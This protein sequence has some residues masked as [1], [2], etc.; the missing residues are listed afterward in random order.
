MLPCTEGDKGDRD[1][2]PNVIMEAATQALPIL[3]TRFAGVPEFIRTGARGCSF[4]PASPTAIAGAGDADPRPR[5]CATAWD[6]GG[7]RVTEGFSFEAGI[8]AVC[9]IWPPQY[10]CAGEASLRPPQKVAAE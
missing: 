10:D 1:G 7:R 2:L 6:S 4:R 8:A 5:A 9:A 3:S